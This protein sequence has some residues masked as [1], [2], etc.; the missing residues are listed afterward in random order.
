MSDCAGRQVEKPI[1][2]PKNVLYKL[3]TNN[4]L[5]TI[6]K[7]KRAP[8]LES[9]AFRYYIHGLEIT[10]RIIIIAHNESNSFEGESLLCLFE[11]WEKRASWTNNKK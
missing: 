5:V 8:A 6:W 7:K 3:N 10:S 4:K 1:N 2:V 9:C 11:K